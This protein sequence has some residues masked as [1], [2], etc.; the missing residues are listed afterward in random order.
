[1]A[2]RSGSGT[3]RK[4]LEKTSFAILTFCQQLSF[5]EVARRFADERLERTPDSIRGMERLELLEQSY[6]L[7]GSIDITACHRIVFAFKA[8]I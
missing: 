1:M 6:S 8:A 5:T 7:F 3:H 4:R 2:L